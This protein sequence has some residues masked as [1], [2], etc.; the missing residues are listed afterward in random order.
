MEY[1]GIAVLSLS[2]GMDSTSLLLHLLR[3]QYK[4]YSLSFNYG[5]KHSVELIKL[6]KNL[7]YLKSKGFEVENR[8]VD[9]SFI[10]DIFSSALLTDGWKIPK[11]HYAEENMRQTVVPNRNAIFSSILYGY[12]LSIANKENEHVVLSLGVHKGDFQVYPDCR[13]SFYTAIG[14][15]FKEGNWGSEN[16]EFYLPYI[17]S[18]K[19]DILVDVV[20]SCN[21]LNLYFDIVL[22]NTNTCYNPDLEGKSCGKCGSCSERLEAFEKLGRKDPVNYKK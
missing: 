14:E 19:Y 12:A 21:Q 6:E 9:I 18:F 13:P 16:V 22:G 7:E 20:E 4:V 10:K 17:N 2:G 11:G 15:A 5:Q 3:H 1:K 8:I